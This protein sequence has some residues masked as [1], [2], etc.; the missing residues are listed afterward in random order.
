MGGDYKA[1]L[2]R[3]CWWWAIHRLEGLLWGRRLSGEQLH[4]AESHTQLPS[5]GGSLG[6]YQPLVRLVG[7][8]PMPS[9]TP[10]GHH[11]RRIRCALQLCLTA[12]QQNPKGFWVCPSL[13]QGLALPSAEASA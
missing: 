9:T 5:W 12:A 6:L 13:S 8:Q 3:C 11:S 2:E 10:G 4:S 1:D 7:M